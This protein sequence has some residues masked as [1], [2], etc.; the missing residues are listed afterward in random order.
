MPPQ[1]ASTVAYLMQSNTYPPLVTEKRIYDFSTAKVVRPGSK[2]LVNIEVESYLESSPENR[3]TV[4][5][6][7]VKQNG[8]W[9]L[10][11][12]TY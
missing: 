10:D 5:I 4:R 9:Y 11:S 12:G 3:I 1:S 2:E 6:T 7:M 8:E